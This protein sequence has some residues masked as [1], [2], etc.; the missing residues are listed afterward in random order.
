MWKWCLCPG[1]MAL[2]FLT[3][4]RAPAADKPTPPSW[5][6][7]RGP[8]MQGYSDDTRAPLTWSETENLLWKTRLPGA[9]NS[10]PIIWGDHVF[11]TTASNEGKRLQVVCLNA[12]DGRI[13]WQQ[14]AS[15]G[16]TP[17]RTHAWNGYASPS[18]TTDGVFVYAFFGTPGLFCYDFQGKLIWKHQ[19]GL[20]TNGQG[21]GTAASPFL[22]DDLIIQNCDNDG[23]KALPKGSK[24]G[25]TAPMALVAL[26]KKTGEVVW[27]T[28]RD[29]GRGFSTPCLIPTVHGRVDLVL[30][31]STSAC[32]YD[33]RTG[34]ERWRCDRSDVKDQHKFGE[35]MP[36]FNS[37]GLFI[38][39]GRPGPCQA[40]RMPDSGIVTGAQVLWQGSR[41]DHRDVA[42]PIL[43]NGRIFCSDSKGILNAYDFKT[44]NQLF[45]GP[46]NTGKNKSLASPVLVR[47]KVLWLLDDGVTVVQEPGPQ[48]KVTGRNKLGEGNA[49]DFGASPA[50]ADGKLYLRSQT[51]LYCIGQAK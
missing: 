36:V 34:K 42:S 4:G 35:P 13:L 29:M 14:V 5:T 43:V 1:L 2:V 23:P 32:G 37:E 10:T 20:F 50:I 47:G 12:H 24:A 51:Y 8:T 33:P 41:K 17:D 7:W 11:L 19:F 16:F 9:G 27:T 28:P 39:S 31:G 38:L 30:N 45:V 44:G 49:L 15:D 22:F 48:L 26:N 25:S 3:F 46:I 18:C 40:I 21:W 6:H